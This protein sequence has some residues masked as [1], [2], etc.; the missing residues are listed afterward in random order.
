MLFQL[1]SFMKVIVLGLTITFVLNSAVLAQIDPT[2]AL[3]GVPIQL[4][5]PLVMQ[6]QY[7]AIRAQQAQREATIAQARL[8][9]EQR[10]QLQNQNNSQQQITNN[11]TLPTHVKEFLNSASP[12]LYLY[13]DFDQVVFDNS[14][15]INDTMIKLMSKNKLAADIAYY[16]GGHRAEALAISQMSYSDA[17]RSIQAISERLERTL[18]R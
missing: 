3:R 11:Q 17:E 10:R 6:Q 12:R 5:N 18:Q 9:D 1:K 8:M 2:I 13:P 4:Q 15:A 7:E 16:L 14:L